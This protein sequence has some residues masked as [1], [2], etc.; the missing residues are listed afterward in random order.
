ME[1]YSWT[2]S[3]QEINVVVHVPPGTKSSFVV[4]EIKKNHLKVGL[5][6]QPPIIDVSFILDELSTF[7]TNILSMMQKESVNVIEN[8]EDGCSSD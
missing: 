7:V 1:K 3:L 4:C 2:Q 6:G 8:K 5:K